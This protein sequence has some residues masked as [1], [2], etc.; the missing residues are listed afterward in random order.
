MINSRVFWILIGTSIFFILL[1]VKL[2]DLQVLQND[3]YDFYAK[4]QQN[5]SDLIKAERGLIYD[6]NNILLVYNRNDI[7][8]LLDKNAFKP[9][10][11]TTV[12][13]KLSSL[14]KNKPSFYRQLLESKSRTVC[15]ERKVPKE[16]SLLLR[17][18]NLPALY[19]KEDPTRIYHYNSLASHILG[20]VDDQMNGVDGIESFFND[21]LKG[22][23]GIRQVERSAGGRMITVSE[24]NTK[25]AVPGLNIQLTIDKK[26][27]AILE[28]ELLTGIK[29][30]EAASATG[31]I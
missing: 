12:T 8:F 3:E 4:R 1:L 9:K 28:E 23:D 22:E 13:K 31:I 15:V 29:R 20:Y 19:V 10:E 30:Y 6:R 5:R 11:I 18:L 16:K 7:S 27:Q 17:N 14:F 26:V 2:F 25:P 24:E 21:A